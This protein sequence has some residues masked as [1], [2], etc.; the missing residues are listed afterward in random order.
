MQP[1]TTGDLSND[2]S[3][4]AEYDTIPTGSSQRAELL[5]RLDG[6]EV[7]VAIIGGGINGAVAAAALTAAGVSVALVERGD[8]SSFTSQ[9][10]SNLIWGGFKYLQTFEFGLVRKLCVSRNRL[11]DAYPSQVE[12]IE[13]LATFDDVSPYPVWLAGMGAAAYWAIGSFAT[14]P[15]KVLRP[16]K[17]E[18]L[19]PVIDT[20]TAKGGLIYADAYLPDNDAR[21][22]FGFIMGA[23]ERGALAANYTEASSVRFDESGWSM[24]LTD[25][26]DGSTRSLRARVVV[27]ATGPWIDEV[28]AMFGVTTEHR[29]AHSKGIHLI[30]PR[31]G[32]GDRVFAFFDEDERL[33][34][35]IPMGDRSVI[36]TTDT[37]VDD[38]ETVVTDED[39][40][41]VLRQINARLDL[42]EPLTMDSVI[43][44][45]CG[46][47][48]LVVEA[49]ND[50]VTADW[51][52]LSRKHEIEL[53]RDRGVVSIFGGKLTDCLNV[54]EEV[55]DAIAQLGVPTGELD[56]AWYGEPPTEDYERFVARVESI[57]SID[58]VSA[59]LL[60]RRYGLRAHA[61][62]DRIE[63]RPD[64][65]QPIWDDPRYLRA[66]VVEIGEREMVATV[67]DF[68]RRRTGLALTEMNDELTELRDD[69]AELLGLVAIPAR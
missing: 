14:T 31:I 34:Y 44:E 65:G 23:I 57:S 33:Y 32:S 42:D 3:A 63:A 64:L 67:D 35:V 40:E 12:P 29:I 9:E 46:V 52:Q 22:T 61:V 26:L 69:L 16:R 2:R 56:D 5:D 17:V 43:A 50:D 45:R 54:G 27:N 37:R 8:F 28:N 38:P 53:D 41:F 6:A 15:P 36:G 13:F 30:V 24:Q 68:L 58:D 4:N 59:G 49:D 11:I 1:P 48:P 60:W 25:Q 66:E 51:L 21:F 62:V 20:S 7:D 39:R 19:E 10:S 55:V 18:E 47:R